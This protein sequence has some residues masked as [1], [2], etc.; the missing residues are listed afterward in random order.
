MTNANGLKSALKVPLLPLLY[1][2]TS[3]IL[4]LFLFFPLLLLLLY[5]LLLPLVIFQ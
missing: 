4:S 3:Y 1:L 5:I 2:L